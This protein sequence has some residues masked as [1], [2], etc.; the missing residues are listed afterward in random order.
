MFSL[1]DSCVIRNGSWDTPLFILR[2]K[3]FSPRFIRFRNLY[4]NI[5]LLSELCRN[6]SLMAQIGDHTEH[7]VL[8]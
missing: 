7:M 2:Q 5:G 8:T 4:I 1:K 6:R 3:R